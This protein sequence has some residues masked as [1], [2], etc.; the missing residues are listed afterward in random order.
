M[1]VKKDVHFLG[2]F[3]QMLKVV[4]IV[5]SIGTRV[6]KKVLLHFIGNNLKTSKKCNTQG[7]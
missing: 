3:M 5:E 6:V 4:H 2:G 1:L 7:S